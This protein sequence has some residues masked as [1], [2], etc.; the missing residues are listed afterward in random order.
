M[1]PNAFLDTNV[2]LYA[3]MHELPLND[4]RKRPEIGRA[5]V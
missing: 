1:M 4:Q 3:A 2:L 5:H